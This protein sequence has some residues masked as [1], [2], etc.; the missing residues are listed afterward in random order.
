MI[1]CYRA[2]IIYLFLYQGIYF[3]L[4]ED[5]QFLVHSNIQIMKE[6]DSYRIWDKATSMCNNKKIT[7]DITYLLSVGKHWRG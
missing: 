1:F 6:R 2:G 5:F 3:S 4:N 7:S